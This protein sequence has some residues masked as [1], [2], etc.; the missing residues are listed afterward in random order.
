MTPAPRPTLIQPKPQTEV[1][2]L[3]KS[4]QRLGKQYEKA[5]EKL[6][7]FRD[8]LRDT[9]LELESK[10]RQLEV[11]KRLLS[12]LEGE[13]ND[14]E[15][16]GEVE[17]LQNRRLESKLANNRDVTE[18]TAKLAK[19]KA[20]VSEL[21]E[22]LHSSQTAL[23]LSEETAE[24]HN[25]EV[26]V[27]KQALGL[28]QDLQDVS[29]SGQAQLLQALAKSQEE[30]ASLA[31]RLSDQQSHVVV[32]EEQLHNMHGEVDRLV[33]LKHD[34]EDTLGKRSGNLSLCQQDLRESQSLNQELASQMKRLQNELAEETSNRSNAQAEVD[35]LTSKLRL[36]TDK[37][38]ATE[39]SSKQALENLRQEVNLSS[40][41][42]ESRLEQAQ[43][44]ANTRESGLLAQ[45]SHS[46]QQVLESEARLTQCQKDAEVESLRQQARIGALEAAVEAARLREAGLLGDLQAHRDEVDKLDRESNRWQSE[47]MALKREVAS[48]ADRAEENSGQADSERRLR[49][50]TSSQLEEER[51][52]FAQREEQFDESLGKI[53]G[54]LAALNIVNDRL[55]SDVQM[56]QDQLASAV[57]NR[58]NLERHVEDLTATITSLTGSKTRLQ[59]TMLDQLS[60]FKTK[61]AQVEQENV[62]L[63][64]TLANLDRRAQLQK[65]ISA[66]EA[67]SVAAAAA[68]AAAA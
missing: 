10:D 49:I 27:L 35:A 64:A 62:T 14:L 2:I 29:L 57:A 47:S 61:L 13:K 46:K 45:L 5:E 1:E 39:K 44:Q 37:L 20:K 60:L 26:S 56:L 24:R 4:F 66:A 65:S 34:L 38:K 18:L 28:R 31:Q 43:A 11:A 59:T 58:T 19:Y 22:A 17:R 55:H 21:Q 53:R 51:R 30:A 63:R 42:Y 48:L 7:D 67:S 54:E 6:G 36:L 32:L 33:K 41:R 15:A 12:R 3:K 50:Q 25:A 52:R 68:A 40:D 9:R 23:I 16:A 8:K